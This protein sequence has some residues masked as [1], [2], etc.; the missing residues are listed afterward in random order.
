MHRPAVLAL[1]II[2]AAA[3][4]TGDSAPSSDA[5]D[6]EAVRRIAQ[7]ATA[8][9]QAGDSLRLSALFADDAIIMTDGGPSVTG[10]AEIMASF[11]EMLRQF[12]SRATIEPAEVEVAGDWAFMR[13]AVTGSLEPRTGGAAIPLDAKEIVIARR[14]ADGSWKVARLIG[15][16][17]RPATPLP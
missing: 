13:T 1:A 6:V 16:S 7:E 11:G 14:Q 9:H 15:N 2:A 10:R 3:C 12:T 5:A 4:R 17:N 8:A